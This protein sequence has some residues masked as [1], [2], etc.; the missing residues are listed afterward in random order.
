M[1]QHSA[2]YKALKDSGAFDL[3]PGM[4][5]GPCKSDPVKLCAWK[6]RRKAGHKDLIAPVAG[7]GAARNDRILRREISKKPAAES[8]EEEMESIECLFAR[9][10]YDSKEKEFEGITDYK[11][12]VDM[13]AKA[14][15]LKAKGLTIGKVLGHGDYGFVLEG[16]LKTPSGVKAVAIKYMGSHEI[17][18]KRI[19]REVYNHRMMYK[20]LPHRVPKLYK[21]FK[22]KGLVSDEWGTLPKPVAHYPHFLVM[23]KISFDLFRLF[24]KYEKDDK[25]MTH[26]L[27]DIKKLL[28]EL[29]QAKMVHGDFDFQ[30][31]GYKMVGG[32]PKMYMIDFEYSWRTT[33]D[34]VPKDAWIL[35]GRLGDSF[36]AIRK[37]IDFPDPP[38]GGYD[39]GY[40]GKKAFEASIKLPKIP[41]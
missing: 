25:V 7:K 32:K 39:E 14:F 26:M 23:E 40:F 17:D 13:W 20:A 4:N 9:S 35:L 38:E 28:Q 27:K 30:N 18:N 24:R 37:S 6:L 2:A 3:K 36:E 12:F 5:N 11:T 33:H 8:A 22:I 29:T 1:A 21:V 19:A 10:G 31:I 16:T 15:D 34:Y 41:F